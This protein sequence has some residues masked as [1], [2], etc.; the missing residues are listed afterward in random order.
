MESDERSNSSER[1]GT[2]RSGTT[3]ASVGRGKEWDRVARTPAFE[4]LMRRKK[5]FLVPAVIFFLVF[6][7]SLPV[8]AG[9]TTVL[10]GPAVG[11]MTWAY[12]FAFVQFP[13]VWILCHLYRNRA[14]KWD[15]LVDKARQEASE[16]RTTT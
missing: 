12:V 7:M 11:E 15:G 3:G 13:M 1:E 16:G 8:L 4:D 9:F 2:G 14:N 6:Y 10:D 5:A